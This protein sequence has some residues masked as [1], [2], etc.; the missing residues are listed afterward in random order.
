[1]KY[2]RLT[3]EQFES[4]HTEFANFLAT[5]QIDRHEWEEIKSQRPNVAEQEL[6]IFSD[7]VWEGVLSKADYLEH[8]SPSHVFLFH[9][10]ESHMHSIV[11]KSLDPQMSFITR[12]GLQWLADNLF[13]E[14]TEIRTGTK[15]FGEDRNAEIFE[16]IKQG[17]ILSDGELYKK[18]QS[19]MSS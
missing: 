4:L 16:L 6:D 11:I 15:P 13:T 9:C 19:V 3:K 18:I 1:M 5:Q 17:S 2:S 10:M 8:F 12:E 14:N 7:L